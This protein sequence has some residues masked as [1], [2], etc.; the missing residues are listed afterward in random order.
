MTQEALVAQPHLDAHTQ[1][2]GTFALLHTRYAQDGCELFL[3]GAESHVQVNGR[4][5][6]GL[7]TIQ[8][9]DLLAVEGESWL[10]V[11]L[12]RPEPVEAPADFA[13]KPCPLCGGPLALAPVVR[14]TCGSF[15]HFQRPDR[16]DDV[17]ALNCYAAAGAC[18]SCAAPLQ[19]DPVVIPAAAE[20]MF[21]LE[22]DA[23]SA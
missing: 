13:D 2:D 22:A 7:T 16:P 5:P 6:F 20:M 17:D 9:G 21:D 10:V 1:S 23:L 19:L 11:Q 18:S 15:Y 3:V 8:P 12:W 14:H 4:R